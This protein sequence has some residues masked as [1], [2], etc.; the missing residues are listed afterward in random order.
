[1]AEARLNVEKAVEIKPKWALTLRS[2]GELEARDK[3]PDEACEWFRKALEQTPDDQRAVRGLCRSLLDTSRSDE[4]LALIEEHL[5]RKPDSRA[6]LSCRALVHV[7]RG[8][9]AL[10]EADYSSAETIS[11][12]LEATHSRGLFRLQLGKFEGAAAD[13]RRALELD[14]NQV[15]S[16]FLLAIAERE[17]GH[18]EAGQAAIQEARRHAD[19]NDWPAKILRYWG[20]ELTAEELVAAA[21]KDGQRCEAFYYVGEQVHATEGAAAARAWFEKCVGVDEPDFTEYR[22]AKWRL[23]QK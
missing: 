22:L 2:M 6:L 21:D 23:S 4:A 17:T 16:V 5:K 3:H 10:A 9:L 15:Y 18:A 1:L 20:G 12:T 13:L 8:D 19:P 11:E 7:A 14:P